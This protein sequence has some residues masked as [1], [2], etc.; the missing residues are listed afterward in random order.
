MNTP[1][2]NVALAVK[3]HHYIALTFPLCYKLRQKVMLGT[4]LLIKWLN[5]DLG[6]GIGFRDCMD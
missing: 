1:A 2:R 3:M 5:K 6:E 4:E